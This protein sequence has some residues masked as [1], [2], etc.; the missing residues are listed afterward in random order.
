MTTYTLEEYLP[1]AQ[2]TEKPLIGAVKDIIIIPPWH[3][4]HLM[5]L[6]TE[7]GELADALKRHYIY[8]KPLDQVNFTEE[9]GDVLWYLAGFLNNGQLTAHD[10]Q[11]A[12]EETVILPPYF[13]NTH[14]WQAN[15]T[16]M[17]RGGARLVIELDTLH[18]KALATAAARATVYLEAVLAYWAPG[19]T[20]GE[21]M[22]L[23]IKKLAKRY[24]EKYTDQ[25]ALIRNLAE[26]RAALEG[27]G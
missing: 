23:N 1:L 14:S 13:T 7:L 27:K 4:H 26:E 18:P 3:G 20:L 12:L 2:R 21:A 22:Y 5:G 25:A 15:A 11:K 8:G 24:G 19:H 16:T 17:V 9:V 6:M 10:V